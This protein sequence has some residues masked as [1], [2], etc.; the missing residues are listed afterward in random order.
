MEI[1]HDKDD[2]TGLIYEESINSMKKI[3]DLGKFKIGANNT[4]EFNYFKKEVM[5]SYY[6]CMRNIFEDLKNQG[7]VDNCQFCDTDLRKGWRPCACRGSGYT[8]IM[9]DE[10]EESGDE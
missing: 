3:L 8:T 6:N 7:I 10:Y 2:L 1:Q 4:S 5:D 9:E